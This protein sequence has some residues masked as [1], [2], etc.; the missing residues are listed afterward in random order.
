VTSGSSYLG[1]Y[2][3]LVDLGQTLRAY[4]SAEDAKIL[5]IFRATAELHIK[6]TST[7]GFKAFPVLITGENSTS[8]TFTRSTSSSPAVVVDDGVT[9]KYSEFI[10]SELSS[11]RI[12]TDSAAHWLADVRID[13]TPFVQLWVKGM[14]REFAQDSTERTKCLFGIVVFSEDDAVSIDIEGWL[15]LAIGLKERPF[16]VF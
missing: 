2:S 16:G 3:N 6:K 9:G 12:I 10:F 14:N 4:V 15:S 13:L 5:N 8:V 1:F 7:A 11:K